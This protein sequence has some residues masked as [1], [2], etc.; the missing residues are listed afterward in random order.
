M[1]P[2]NPKN[3]RKILKNIKKILPAPKS[4][5]LLNIKPR[6]FKKNPENFPKNCKIIKHPQSSKSTHKYAKTQNK[7]S[8]SS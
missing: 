6:K 3:A 8:K 1:I 4:A 7:F 5:Q 2:K